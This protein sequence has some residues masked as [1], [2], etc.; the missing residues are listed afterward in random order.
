MIN[1]ADLVSII[2]KYYLNG[3]IE[4][5]KWE[6]EDQNLTIKFTC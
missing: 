1:K 4:S 2:S 5:V 3:L 6:I